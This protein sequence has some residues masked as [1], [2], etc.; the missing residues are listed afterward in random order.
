M[1]KILRIE[2]MKVKNYRTFWILLAITI[3]SIPGLS[4]AIYNLT[5]NSFPKVKGKSILGSPFAF[6]DVWQNISWNS[7][8]TFIIPAI[9]VITL[10][11]NE[12]TYK[13]HRQNIIDGWS[14]SQFIGV[15]LIELVLLSVLSTIVVLLTVLA[16]GFIGN[17]VPE[18]APV[19]QG[20]RFIFFYFVQMLSFSMIA[21]LLAMLIRRAGLAIGAFLIYILAEK[22]IVGIGHGIYKSNVVDYLPEEVTS[23]LIPQSYIKGIPGGGNWEHELP[24]YLVVAALYLI[25]YCLVTG[26]RFLK[27]DL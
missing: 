8:W 12:F 11:T 16:F 18:G 7:G 5:N 15:K 21:F 10:T 27:S 17:K 13:T 4:Y 23:M 9:L 6:P 26:R 20:V 14:R 1:L 25:V 19:W 24:G 22:I 2:W 3:L